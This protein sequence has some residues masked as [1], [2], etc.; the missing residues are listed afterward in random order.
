[1]K[2]IS[3]YRFNKQFTVRASIKTPLILLPDS[4][5]GKRDRVEAKKKIGF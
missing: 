2:E 4:Y 3:G 5:R 1:L